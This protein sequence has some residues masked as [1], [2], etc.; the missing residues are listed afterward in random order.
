MSHLISEGL[1]ILRY[2]D[3]VAKSHYSKP[4]KVR[5][6]G[7]DVL[8]V[9]ATTMFSE[10]AGELA[11]GYPFGVAWFQRQDGKYQFSLRSTEAGVDVSLVAKSF[12]GGGHKN[13][14]GFE[15]K[16]MSEAIESVSYT[17]AK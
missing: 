16:Q 9:N 11:K 15:V 6:A 1:A 3:E 14:A 17:G 7:H 5:I 12:G 2:Q 8:M 4:I 10:V 13:A